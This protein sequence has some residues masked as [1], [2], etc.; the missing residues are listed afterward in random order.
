[1]T[2]PAATPHHPIAIVG[3][4]MAGL[5]CARRLTLAG[6]AV[7]LFD[8]GRAPGGRLATRRMQTWQFDHGAQYVTARDG[9]FAAELADLVATGAAAPWEAGAAGAHVGTPG[10]SALPRAFA[11]DMTIHCGTPVTAL[12]RTQDG[13]RLRVGE[14]EHRATRLVMTL[15]APQAAALL[16]DDPLAARLA[17]VRMAPCWTLMAAVDAPAPFVVRRDATAALTW[18]SHDGAKPG[19]VAHDRITTWVAQASEAFST[20]HLERAP[21]AARALMLP[22]LLAAIG[23]DPS[24]VRFATAHRWRFARVTA[25]LGTPFLRDDTGTLYLGGD[26]CLAA[27]VEAAYASGCAIA[28]ALIAAA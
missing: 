17:A 21:E 3:A 7:V 5:A 15:P 12:A 4:G 19:R 2:D 14:T 9:G 22:S 6:H 27:R 25:P 28:D 13:W 8:K 20:T 1:M 11:A 24:A 16:G 10:M 23:A 26:W 18:I